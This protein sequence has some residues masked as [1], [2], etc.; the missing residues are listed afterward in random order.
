M[1]VSPFSLPTPPHERQKDRQHIWRGECEN[2]SEWISGLWLCRMILTETQRTGLPSGA[3]LALAW[4]P[5]VASCHSALLAP[6]HPS[7]SHSESTPA[8]GQSHPPRCGQPLGC[9]SDGHPSASAAERR[10]RRLLRASSP[11]PLLAGC[12]G[13]AV[14]R[15][16]QQQQ[17]RRCR[18]WGQQ[19]PRSSSLHVD[20]PRPPPLPPAPL[21]VAPTAPPPGPAAFSLARSRLR[22]AVLA[23]TTVPACC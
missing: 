8:P 18:R 16:Q 12:P 9:A 19:Q 11:P 10:R 4:A 3:L 15:Q 5:P 1:R 14:N 13:A 21:V 2:T 7:P 20:A 22:S 6:L 23:P 17:P